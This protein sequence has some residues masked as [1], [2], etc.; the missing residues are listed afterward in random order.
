MDKKLERTP[1]TKGHGYENLRDDEESHREYLQMI[2]SLIADMN[3]S[4]C[5]SFLN[6]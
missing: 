6:S 3:D 4:V 1:G 5:C 2:Y